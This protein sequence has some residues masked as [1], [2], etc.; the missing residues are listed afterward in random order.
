[1][2]KPKQTT[3]SG[4]FAEPS[5]R[6]MSILVW[7]CLIPRRVGVRGADDVVRLHGFIAGI[8]WSLLPLVR[9][10]VGR[11][12]KCLS[13]AAKTGDKTTKRRL[14]IAPGRTTGLHAEWSKWRYG[15][16][17]D[18]WRSVRTSRHGVKAKAACYD[19]SVR[20]LWPRNWQEFGVMLRLWSLDPSVRTYQRKNCSIKSS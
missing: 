8:I 5:E 6:L 15:I 10:C 18:E 2:P 4:L 12:Q 9:S 11:V 13:D 17:A 14:I 16:K 7:F 3:E 20:W 1:M 19:L